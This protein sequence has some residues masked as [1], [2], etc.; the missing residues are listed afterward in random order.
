[1]ESYPYGGK[2]P[3]HSCVC[4]TLGKFRTRFGL[5]LFGQ[6][7]PFALPG[8]GIADVDVAAG[9]RDFEDIAAAIDGFRGKALR[10]ALERMAWPDEI[11]HVSSLRVLLL[12][13]VSRW[14]RGPW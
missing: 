5:D 14:L 7:M 1:M 12:L 9:A 13:K 11:D 2:E 6:G 10:L 8:I 4:V 3:A